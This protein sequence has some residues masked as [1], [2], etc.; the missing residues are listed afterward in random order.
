MTFQ[1]AISFDIAYEQWKVW[2]SIKRS[3]SQEFEISYWK[4]VQITQRENNWQ[5]GHVI[6]VFSL[7]INE[8]KE[9]RRES[10]KVN[11]TALGIKI[12]NDDVYASLW[13][14]FLCKIHKHSNNPP[15]RYK[16][17]LR[18]SQL[19]FA[20]VRCFFSVVQLIFLSIELVEYGQS[21]LCDAFIAS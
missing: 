16:I 14:F 1:V 2:L 13:Y 3:V 6:F 15:V 12:S 11:E 17:P 19:F 20:E 9:C 21:N 18:G 4:V 8:I 5:F 7:R 10:Q